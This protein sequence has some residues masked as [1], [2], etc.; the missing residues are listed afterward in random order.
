[1]N[2]LVGGGVVVLATVLAACGWSSLS[3][4]STTSTSAK[5]PS[6][7]FTTAEVN[8]GQCTPAVMVVRH[9]ED[10]DNPKAGEPDILNAAGRQHAALY[11]KLFQTYLAESHSI[12]PGGAE[13][14]VCPIGKI[15]AIDPTKNNGQNVNPGTNPYCTIEPLAES[16]NNQLQAPPS[17]AKPFSPPPECPGQPDLRIQ[18]K[19]PAGVS[20]STVYNWDD[21][22]R[23][24]TLLDNGTPTPTSTVIAWDKQGLN[25]NADDLNK[26]INGKKLGTYYPPAVPLLKALPANPAAIVGSGDYF[27]PQRDYLYVFAQQNAS[28]KFDVAKAYI[29][30]FSN[31]GGADWHPCDTLS[32]KDHPN[33]IRVGAKIHPPPEKPPSPSPSC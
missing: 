27:T 15:I 30:D 7:A 2:G 3:S 18:V 5:Q 9:A 28:G 12:G 31:N 17:Q 29:Q 21:P 16:I 4:A 32:G 11:P 10:G 13:A 14:T 23:L 25:P 22:A 19:D 26:N 6:R 20:Y 8:P 24:K 1:V 33:D